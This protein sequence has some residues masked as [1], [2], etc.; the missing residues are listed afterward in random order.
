MA[1]TVATRDL[2][3]A[4]GKRKCSEKLRN[5]PALLNPVLSDFQLLLLPPACRCLTF[6]VERQEGRV[7]CVS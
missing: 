3:L 5:L 4:Q 7:T 2:H 6:T 1:S